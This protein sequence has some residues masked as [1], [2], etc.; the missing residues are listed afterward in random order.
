MSQDKNLINQA[1]YKSTRNN[2]STM[3]SQEIPYTAL[4]PL[5]TVND[6]V[7]F[8]I[9]DQNNAVNNKMTV[10]QL[11]DYI[12]ALRTDRVL[13]KTWALSDGNVLTLTE[14]ELNSNQKIII[15]TEDLS[16]LTGDF[17]LTIPDTWD[18][19]LG[20]KIEIDYKDSSFPFAESRLLDIKKSNADIIFQSF[21]FKAI[22]T[23]HNLCAPYS[24]KFEIINSEFRNPFGVFATG[25]GGTF[26]GGK[27]IFQANNRLYKMFFIGK[28][29]YG[30]NA[31][32]EIRLGTEILYNFNAGDSF[33]VPYA[34]SENNIKDKVTTC[35][36]R[37]FDGTS[38]IWGM[39]SVDIGQDPDGLK[40]YSYSTLPS[41]QNI[42]ANTLTADIG[43]DEL[44]YLVFEGEL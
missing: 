3:G 28:T 30:P 33:I 17:E 27:V 21:L 42:T 39:E 9:V 41:Q 34:S 37:N 8:S 5:L 31:S 13:Y 12:R 10:L 23:S 29:G 19:T 40:L 22:I 2:P 4:D 7:L 20:I 26:F 18:D 35:L 24:F 25:K 14:D 6:N 36:V 43:S 32:A 15:T 1:S 38:E 44:F 16:S 11:Y